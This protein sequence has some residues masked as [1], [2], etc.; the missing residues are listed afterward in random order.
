M[1]W[2][3]VLGISSVLPVRREV[4]LATLSL[5]RLVYMKVACS[6]LV[7]QAGRS[8]LQW[9]LAV[10]LVQRPLQV[11]VGWSVS[12]HRCLGLKQRDLGQSSARWQ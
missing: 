8:V 2:W 6:P 9:A 1:D 4:V 12:F 3:I 10:R 11:P 5:Q 7:A